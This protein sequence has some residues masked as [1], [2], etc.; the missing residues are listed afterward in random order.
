MKWRAPIILGGLLIAL[1]TLWLAARAFGATPFGP[2][3]YRVEMP[4]APLQKQVALPKIYGP[5]GRP[6]VVID[7]GHGGH[8][9]GAISPVGGAKEKDIT[10]AIAQAIRDKLVASGR[11]RVALTRDNDSFLVLTERYE[12]AR[13][14]EANLFISVH[15]DSAEAEG[16]SGATIYT[17]SEVASD[18]EAARLAARENKVDVINGV[19][20]SSAGDNVTSILIGLSQRETMEKSSEF[21]DLLKREADPYVTFR[22]VYHRFAGLIVLKAPDMPAVLFES[23]YITSEKDVAYLTTPEGRARI[24]TGIAKA[25]ETYFARQTAGS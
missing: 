18:R 1:A 13:R 25:V 17:L 6:L 2:P 21:A 8:D 16:A 7:A 3:A 22:S 19:D 9:P 14:M 10:L 24:A 20:L 23:G 5:P 11:V 4:I 15:A 12:L